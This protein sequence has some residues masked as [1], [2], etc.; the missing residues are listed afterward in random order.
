MK[1]VAL[2][3]AFIFAVVVLG[4]LLH[5]ATAWLVQAAND[6]VSS[7]CEPGGPNYDGWCWSR[8]YTRFIPTS[9]EPGASLMLDLGI[10]GLIVAGAFSLVARR[11]RAN[12]DAHD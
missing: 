3:F 10:S 2:S 9:Y 12:L 1:K 8:P 11:R 7:G 4:I 5:P 6:G